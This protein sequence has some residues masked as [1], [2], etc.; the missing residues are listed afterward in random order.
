MFCGEEAVEFPNILK[1]YPMKAKEMSMVRNCFPLCPK[2]Q[3]FPSFQF[4]QIFPMRGLTPATV[5]HVL[6]LAL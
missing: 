3:N 1:K 6:S 5:L 4:N 2:L